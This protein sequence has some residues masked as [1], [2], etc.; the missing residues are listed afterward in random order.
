MSALS[1]H[2]DNRSCRLGRPSPAVAARPCERI[3]DGPL[4][5]RP[6]V[7]S[8]AERQQMVTDFLEGATP[9]LLAEERNNP[10]GGG[11]WHPTVGDC[12]RVILEEEWAQLRCIRRAFALLA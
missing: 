1:S 6:G 4:C 3:V 2:G 7:R 12:V 9:A 8:R 5:A 10:W 11:D